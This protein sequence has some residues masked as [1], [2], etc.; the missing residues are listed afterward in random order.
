MDAEQQ[1]HT[2]ASEIDRLLSLAQELSAH[3]QR[4]L[5]FAAQQRAI[6]TPV[7]RLPDEIL[8]QIFR[9]ACAGVVFTYPLSKPMLTAVAIS[10]VCHRWR[11]IAGT[12][13]H[14]AARR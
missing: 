5:D 8:E 11:T 7:R 13:L 14:Q 3:R 6:I 4:L 12:S 10:H 1:A 2:L 9:L